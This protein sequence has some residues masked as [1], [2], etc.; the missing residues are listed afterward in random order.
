[1]MISVL[2]LCVGL[3]GQLQ[4]LFWSTSWGMIYSYRYVTFYVIDKS[5]LTV[6]MEIT[7]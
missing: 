1:M 7:E 3:G 6:K 4:R 5:C 2:Y